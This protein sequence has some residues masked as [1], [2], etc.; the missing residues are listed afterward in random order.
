MRRS[1]LLR[2]RLP[3]GLDDSGETL[4]FTRRGGNAVLNLV[5]PS[6]G[7]WWSI[8][9]SE[10]VPVLRWAGDADG[11]QWLPGGEL[12]REKDSITNMVHLSPYVYIQR[13]N[14]MRSFLLDTGKHSS[15]KATFHYGKRF[16]GAG[17]A[18]ATDGV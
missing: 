15:N 3:V 14:R 7:Q 11:W 2:P 16:I 18:A 13:K 6:R 12:V 17:A 4:F 9:A 10:L 1:Q 5:S 8:P